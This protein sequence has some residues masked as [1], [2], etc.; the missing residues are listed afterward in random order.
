MS[1]SWLI[2]TR[3]RFPASPP[4]EINIMTET[5]LIAMLA[6]MV[7]LLFRSAKKQ[8]KSARDVRK[9]IVD[10]AWRRN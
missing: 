5:V 2:W 7:F 9:R 4:F 8:R 10:R 6:V 1:V 3:V